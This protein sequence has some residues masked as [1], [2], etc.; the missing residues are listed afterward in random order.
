LRLS[1]PDGEI[2]LAA[3]SWTQ[4][5]AFVTGRVKAA[6]D[7][8]GRDVRAGRLPGE[9]DARNPTG[10]QT[11]DL[12]AVRSAEVRHP[13]RRKSERLAL[14]ITVLSLVLLKAAPPWGGF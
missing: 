1:F 5:S 12:K 4:S 2:V 11:F 8:Q 6:R 9:L 13:D 14:V 3:G 10:L 7:L